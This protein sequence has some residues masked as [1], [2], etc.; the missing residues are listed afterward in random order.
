MKDYDAVG[1]KSYEFVDVILD[2]QFAN[3][4]IAD[5]ASFISNETVEIECRCH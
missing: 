5:L 2:T 3:A 1:V 4:I